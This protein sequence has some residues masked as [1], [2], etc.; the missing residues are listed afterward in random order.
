MIKASEKLLERRK[1]L[2]LD[3]DEVEK[4]TKIKSEYLTLIENGDFGDLPSVS[5]ASG[6]VK[7]YAKFLGIAEKEIMPLFRREFN[8]DSGYRVIP[9]GFEGREEF[10][11]KRLRLNQT[12]LLVGIVFVFLIAYVLFQ[13][14]YAF[15]NPP[16]TVYTPK[17]RSVVATQELEVSGKTEPETNII[18]N[19][20]PVTVDQSGNFLKT[21]S[22]FPGNFIL[23]IEAE[24]KFGKKTSKKIIVEIRS[25]Y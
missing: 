23:N 17:D 3:L 15:I 4:S 25:G 10:P 6:F 2:G 7:N 14:R 20:D 9:K 16:L 13:Y 22:V 8:P 5:H 11:L 1:E 19:D 24:N 12:L 21:I 18:I